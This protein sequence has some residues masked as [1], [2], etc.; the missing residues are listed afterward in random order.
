MKS[1]RWMKKL[2]YGI[3]FSICSSVVFAQGVD[4]F[5]NA[6]GFFG[7]F[8]DAFFQSELAVFGVTV[9]A[10]A[11]MFY[12]MFV[13]L[14]AKIPVFK[15][16]DKNLANKYGRIV[17][18]CL[19]LLSSLGIFGLMYMQ[20]LG[21]VREVLHHTLGTFSTFAGIIM[22]LLVFGIVYFGFGSLSDEDRWKKAM[23]ATG[24]AL[25]AIGALMARPA[26]HALGWLIVFIMLLVWFARGGL[27]G[28]SGGVGKGG[29]RDKEGKEKLTKITLIG[30]VVDHEGKQVK[31][32][33]LKAVDE[34][35]NDIS[36]AKARTSFYSG[37]FTMKFNITDDI[38]LED[39]TG[40]KDGI[41]YSAGYGAALRGGRRISGIDL[42]VGSDKTIRGIIVCPDAKDVPIDWDVS[43]VY[44][45]RDNK[46]KFTIKRK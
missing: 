39:V 18:L 23:W 14:I 19:G 16:D 17:A 33:E 40:E 45:P 11:F 5:V 22:A 38:V 41:N 1:T 30:K 44:H 28:T 37:G 8:L 34:T 6:F 7:E 29:K 20:G 3:A 9:I 2:V 4:N 24:L 25:L 10:F 35:G 27:P 26:L 31:R 12:N 43:G 15:G 32:F 46:V 21:S 42:K 13:P 36:G